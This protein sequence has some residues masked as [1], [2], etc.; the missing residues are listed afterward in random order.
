METPDELLLC[1]MNSSWFG[2][3][4]LSVQELSGDA[5]WYR[6]SGTIVKA[7]LST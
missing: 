5:F 1:V 6:S 3:T 4:I 2:R 7:T